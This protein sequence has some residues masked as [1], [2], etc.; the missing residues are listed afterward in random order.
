MGRPQTC[1][2]S[3]P[4]V[5]FNW[6]AAV[7]AQLQYSKTSQF[8]GPAWSIADSIAYHHS[9]SVSS[10]YVYAYSYDL[11]ILRE[12]VQRMAGVEVT[13]EMTGDQIEAMG[14]GELLKQEVRRLWTAFSFVTWP[15]S[16]SL[17]LP[18][19]PFWSVLLHIFSSTEDLPVPSPPVFVSV[20]FSH[21]F[22]PVN[23][24]INQNFYSTN[25]PGKWE[26]KAKIPTFLLHFKQ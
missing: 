15:L 7:S 21:F 13:E 2:N 6:S 24:S 4:W 23:T 1:C 26:L 25:I 20:T 5:M 11:L 3:I 16:L 22:R 17:L 18:T 9:K 19:V 12:V 10:Q 14:G 8:V